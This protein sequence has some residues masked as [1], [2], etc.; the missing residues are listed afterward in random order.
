MTAISQA[1]I[2][3]IGE[4]R[5]VKPDIFCQSDHRNVSVAVLVG[6]TRIP[7]GAAEMISNFAGVG[8]WRERWITYRDA[9]TYAGIVKKGP[10]FPLNSLMLH[11]IIFARH[12]RGLSSDPAGDLPDEVWSYFASGTGLQELYVSPDLLSPAG[13]GPNRPRRALGA[14]AC[15]GAEGQP[16]AG[17]GPST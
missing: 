8:S 2:S 11:G 10:L 7:S 4:W 9:D 1:A 13:L 3:L 16:L 5:R 15:A 12:A 14:Q 17:R 6:L